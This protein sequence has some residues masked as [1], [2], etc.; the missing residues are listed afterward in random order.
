MTYYGGKQIAD[1]FRTVRGNTVKIAEEIPE[2]KYGYS[3]SPD[4]RTVGKM[5]VHIALGPLFSF[6][7]HGKRVTDMKTVNFPEL[8]QKIWAEE[9]KPRNKAE[10][11]AFL[12]SE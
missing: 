5:L 6:E 11:I 3:A 4:T 10:T 12:K 1:A 2:D 8:M 7:I 9:A